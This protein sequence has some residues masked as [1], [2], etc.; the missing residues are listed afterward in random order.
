MLD[1]KFVLKLKLLKTFVRRSAISVA[2]VDIA[3]SDNTAI[4]VATVKHVESSM[5]YDSVK[6]HTALDFRMRAVN[7]LVATLVIRATA[8]DDY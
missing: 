7:V 4:V 6:V 8:V 3:A 2:I 5:N 1:Q